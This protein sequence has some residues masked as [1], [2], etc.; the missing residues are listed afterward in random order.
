[1][2]SAVP[3]WPRLGTEFMPPLDEGTLL[4]MPSTMPGSRI[5]EAEALARGDRSNPRG[6][7]GGRARAREGR[8]GGHRHGPRA[9]VDARDGDRAEAQ[10]SRGGRGFRAKS[11]SVRWMPRSRFRGGE[12]LVDARAR[13]PRHAHDRNSNSRR[14]QDRREQRH[15]DRAH[16]RRRS[17]SLL[18][19]VEERAA[20]SP[21]RSA[22]RRFSTSGGTGRRSPA[23]ESCSTRRKRRF[24]TRSA[25]TT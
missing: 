19:G 7:S 17:L 22:A 9:G 3:L 21:S 4:Y 23:P 13:T 10:R 15:G 16:R 25:A 5:S 6:I 20:S 14:H 24:S 11:S 12:R 8:S 1:M 2:L 18:P